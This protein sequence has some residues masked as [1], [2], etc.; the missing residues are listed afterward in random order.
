MNDLFTPIQTGKK[1][2]WFSSEDETVLMAHV[3]VYMCRAGKRTP[4]EPGHG[5]LINP[6]TTGYEV[7]GIS[8][9]ASRQAVEK[10]LVAGHAVKTADEFSEIINR[11]PAVK[12]EQPAFRS[13]VWR[14]PAH[15][16]TTW[17]VHT[18]VDGTCV[19]GEML[20]QSPSCYE[21]AVAMFESSELVIYDCDSSPRRTSSVF[22]G[23]WNCPCRD[24]DEE[25][26]HVIWDVD[27]NRWIPVH[28]SNLVWIPIPKE[29]CVNNDKLETLMEYNIPASCTPL[30]TYFGHAIPL[31]S[32]ISWTPENKEIKLKNPVFRDGVVVPYNL[33]KLRGAN[34]LETLLQYDLKTREIFRSDRNY[35]T[36]VRIAN[37]REAQ[38]NNRKRR[39]PVVAFF[40]DI[41]C[42]LKDGL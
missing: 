3:D 25:A 18:V 10:G 5:F 15:V 37:E 40:Q 19:S 38:N 17:G 1:C 6:R 8:C 39:H 12:N 29:E 32:V 11:Y 4:L 7:H 13:F 20:P 16:D 24:W 27:K 14:R 35:R 26:T 23:F 33:K 36:T 34:H 9:I 31:E 30:K 28:P 22:P 42:G 2:H 21:E 41:L